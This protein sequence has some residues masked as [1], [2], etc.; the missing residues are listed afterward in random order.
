MRILIQRV[1]QAE[2]KV[3]GKTIGKIGK[4]LLVFVGVGEGDDAVVV[5]KM[6]QRVVKLRIFA[7]RKGKMNLDVKQGGGGGDGDFPIYPVRE[8]GKRQ[9]AFIY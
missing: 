6:A 3:E 8:Y 4:G 5:Q 9:S 1:I 2:V 7:D